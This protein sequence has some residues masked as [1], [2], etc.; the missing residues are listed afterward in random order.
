[1]KAKAFLLMKRLARA[2]RDTF[3]DDPVSASKLNLDVLRRTGHK[4]GGND[5]P[6]QAMPA[7]A[8]K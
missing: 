3:K 8:A 2:A 6:A 7:P 5:A 1:M 4:H